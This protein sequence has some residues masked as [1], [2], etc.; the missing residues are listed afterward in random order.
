MND[1]PARAAVATA[2][3]ACAIVIGVAAR[4]QT[5]DPKAMSGS[6]LAV[7]DLP[8]GTVTVRVVRGSFDQNMAGQRVE[9]TIDT[10]RR[11]ETTDASGRATVSGLPRGARVTAVAVVGQERLVSQEAVVGPTGLRI[12]LVATD[13]AAAARAD[14]DRALAAAPPVRG[15][16]VLGGDSRVVVDFA[17]DKLQVFY[18]LDVV[19]S[20]RSPVDIGG[21]L[22]FDLPRT[23]RGT[24]VMQGSSPQATANGARITVTGPFAPGTTPVR[25]AYELPHGGANV[26]LEQRWPAALQETTVIVARVGNMDASSPQFAST[27]TRTEDDQTFILGLGAGIAAGQSLAVDITGLPHHPRWP[28]YTALAL[29][30]AIMA[31]GIWAAA[32]PSRRRP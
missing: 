2:L 32:T 21:P 23:A 15:M 7:S 22:I 29:A 28:R 16:V 12:I 4:V 27:R 13:P 6:V 3:A 18:L 24:A 9:F 1:H 5:P 30:A 26:R 11:V 10:V 8:A 17:T 31:V 14:E 20:A 19:N 25:I